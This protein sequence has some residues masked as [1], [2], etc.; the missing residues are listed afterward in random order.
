MPLSSVIGKFPKIVRDKKA[1]LYR[2]EG[3]DDFK[4]DNC[5]E[6]HRLLEV[7]GKGDVGGKGEFSAQPFS[8]SIQ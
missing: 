3:N 4:L 2:I 5:S 6:D 8:I 7:E 1:G